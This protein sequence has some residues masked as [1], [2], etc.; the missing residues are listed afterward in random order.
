MVVVV[1]V[2]VVVECLAVFKDSATAAVEN[3]NTMRVA[4]VACKKF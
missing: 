1:V 4:A 3:C 2:V